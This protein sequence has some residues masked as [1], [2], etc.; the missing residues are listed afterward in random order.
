[1]EEY[2]KRKIYEVLR[3]HEQIRVL[4]FHEMEKADQV[5]LS[6]TV[7]VEYNLQFLPT[8]RFEK[9]ALAKQLINQNHYPSEEHLSKIAHIFARNMD[10]NKDL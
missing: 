2:P 10:I 4:P 9:I 3:A 7:E 5:E 6:D 1:M 8:T